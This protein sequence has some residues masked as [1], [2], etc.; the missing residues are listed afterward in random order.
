M[1]AAPPTAVPLLTGGAGPTAPQSVD[2]PPAYDSVMK[3]PSQF[4]FPPGHDGASQVPL[5]PPPAYAPSN[6]SF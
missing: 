2:L 4:A 5:T 1:P 6:C 3:D